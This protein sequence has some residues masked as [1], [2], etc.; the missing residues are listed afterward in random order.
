MR[1]LKG[2]KTAGPPRA[3]SS[4]T[5]RRKSHRLHSKSYTRIYCK[6]M[7]RG[8]QHVVLPLAT[9]KHAGERAVALQQSLCK[10]YAEMFEGAWARFSGLNPPF[11]ISGMLRNLPSPPKTSSKQYVQWTCRGIQGKQRMVSGRQGAA[12]WAALSTSESLAV[13]R[14]ATTKVLKQPY[15][16]YLGHCNA[17]LASLWA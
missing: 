11:R 16:D 9:R 6:R 10:V 14:R 8:K 5:K 4:P 17:W 12:I 1:F 3:I 15:F 13:D 2:N 7:A